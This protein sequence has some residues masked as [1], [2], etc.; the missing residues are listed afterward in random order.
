MITVIA[1]RGIGGLGLNRRSKNRRNSQGNH[2]RCR[3]KCNVCG[4]S[5]N[6]ETFVCF[7]VV[8]LFGGCRGISPGHFQD[9]SPSG[10]PQCMAL[11]G[12]GTGSG[13]K[14]VKLSAL[15]FGH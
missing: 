10:E 14:L 11:V 8:H 7:V 2:K 4:C 6:D 1:I 15:G 9:H 5:L 3:G 12:N 13:E